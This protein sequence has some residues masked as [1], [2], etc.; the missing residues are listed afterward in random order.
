MVRNGLFNI[1]C[2]FWP[3]ETVGGVGFKTWQRAGLHIDLWRSI[4]SPLNTADSTD[5]R[6]FKPGLGGN[7]LGTLAIDLEWQLRPAKG[8]RASCPVS[9]SFP[10]LPHLPPPPSGCLP[11]SLSS[12]PSPLLIFSRSIFKSFLWDGAS[13]SL[14]GQVQLRT[15]SCMNSK[16][17]WSFLMTHLFGSLRKLLLQNAKRTKMSFFKSNLKLA[18]LFGY[19]DR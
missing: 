2:S 14:D 10:S 6:L 13:F 9:A 1:S 11:F 5:G 18:L 16:G 15:D 12:H 19:F 17:L 7:R 3:A 8:Q 4:S